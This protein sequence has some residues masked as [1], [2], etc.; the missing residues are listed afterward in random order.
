[1]I[2]GKRIHPNTLPGDWQQ[3]IA[4]M[5]TLG[6]PAK[7]ILGFAAH[8]GAHGIA[9]AGATDSHL[10]DYLAARQLAGELTVRSATVY[11]QEIVAGLRGLKE[12]APDAPATLICTDSTYGLRLK[13]FEDLAPSLKHEFNKLVE[14]VWRR[15][16]A[17]TIAA[18]KNTLLRSLEMLEKAGTKV[19]SL[20]ELTSSL[21][22]DR[23]EELNYGV[24]QAGLNNARKSFLSLAKDIALMEKD[25][26]RLAEISEF[27]KASENRDGGF[28]RAKL[29]AILRLDQK[30]QVAL[31]THA[32]TTL[33]LSGFSPWVDWRD[34]QAAIAIV[35]AWITS[36]KV[37]NI[38]LAQFAVPLD[39]ALDDNAL[40]AMIL[41]G[42]QVPLSGKLIGPIATFRR[43]HAD[44]WPSGCND[45][46][47]TNEGTRRA[48]CYVSSMATN[49]AA[50]VQVA[51]NLEAIAGAS[52]LAMLRAKVH[53]TDVQKHLGI[54]QEGNFWR[55]YWQLVE[56]CDHDEFKTLVAKWKE[57][58]A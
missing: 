17:K 30:A 45:V 14:T 20:I 32:Q 41:R 58:V 4:T 27:M 24:D 56:L 53:P 51:T 49:L 6:I 38:S 15:R 5:K 29:E 47:L 57:R 26:A 23:L 7:G 36:Q 1:M 18:E 54:V 21:T 13:Q 2:Y 31:L 16:K 8:C 37:G 50:T 11:R 34:G 55:R 10:D 44:R 25:G 39:P 46:F 19:S 48:S 28:S 9:F 40:S 35:L 22:L 42:R 12:L 33:A 3:P 52:V 43:R